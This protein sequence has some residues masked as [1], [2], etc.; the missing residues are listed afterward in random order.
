MSKIKDNSLVDEGLSSIQW[1]KDN[2]PILSRIRKEFEKEKPF[3]GIRIGVSMHLDS[4][5]AVFLQTLKSGGA[6]ISACSCNPLSTEDG[7]AAALSTNMEIFAWSNETADEYYNCLESVIR[8]APGITLDDGGDLLYRMH[9]KFPALLSTF[10]GGCEET[11]T[12]SMRLRAMHD[13][14]EL[15]VPVIDLNNAYSKYLFD[16]RYGSGQSVVEGLISATNI[17]IAGKIIVIVGYGRVGRGLAM[18]FRGMGARVI[19]VETTALLDHKGKSG[20]HKGLEALYDGNWVSSMDD[21][22]SEGDIFITATGSKDVISKH[23]IK[24]MKDNSILANAGHFDHEIDVGSLKNMSKSH[25]LVRP[26]LVRYRL[27]NG[28]SILLLSEGRLVNLSRPTGHGHPIEI[29]DGSFSLQALCIKYLAKSN[30]LKSDINNMIKKPGVYPVPNKIDEMVARY[31]LEE[32]GVVLK[33]P[34]YEQKQYAKKS[35][36]GT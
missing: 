1:A 4:K 20:Y 14:S 21:A 16:N 30:Q 35:E 32:Q 33:N 36:E 27:K 13:K 7:V 26:N 31:A 29:M 12:G 18:R 8:T 28:K 11:S 19:V 15:K 2:M 17:L 24:D 10:I 25:E 34:T 3:L 6:D 22:A 5:A 23:H 9:F